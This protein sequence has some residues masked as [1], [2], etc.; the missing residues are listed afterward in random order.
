MS[1]WR[2][3]AGASFIAVIA[4]YIGSYL[5]V[6]QREGRVGEEVIALDYPRLF[7][8]PTCR[9]LCTIHRPLMRLDTW[10]NGMPVFGVLA[11][12]EE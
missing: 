1:G 5:A 12:A 7:P 6:R 9:F 11:Y 4:L 3:I 2:G 10:L 8:R